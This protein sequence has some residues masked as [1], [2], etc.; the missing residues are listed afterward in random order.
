MLMGGDGAGRHPMPRPAIGD[1]GLTRPD[2]TTPLERDPALLWLDKN[3]NGDPAMADLV[4]GL[5]AG[6][7]PGIL[8]TYP[9]LT[10][11]YHLLADHVGVDPSMIVVTGG[12][13]GGIRSVFDAFV[14]PGDAVLRF[15][16][17]Y[18]MY[19]VYGRIYGAR[20]IVVDYRASTEGPV[21]D[22]DALHSTLASEAPRL[23]CLPNP[24]SPT[25]TVLDLGELVSIAEAVARHGGVLLVDEA[26]HPFDPITAVPLLVDHPNLVVVRTFSKAWALSGLRIGYCVADPDLTRLLHKVRPGYETNFVAVRM[27]EAVLA[28]EEAMLRSVARLNDGRDRFVGEMADLGFR[29]LPSGGNF[30]LVEFG[31]Y[32]PKV[33]RVLEDL[34]LYRRDFGHPSLAGFSRF[35]ATTAD[36]FVPVVARIRTVIGDGQVTS[37]RA[38]D[39]L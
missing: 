17:T 22:L 10:G 27:A 24:A 33:H 31:D 35:S 12:A 16:P 32:A 3:E 30:L 15:E 11:L 1:A 9:E 39:D 4:A 2:W 26:Y 14:S 5:L 29:T 38:S 23:V 21:L 7:D 20:Q 18:A 36:R 13:D 8:S 28:E 34:V 37:A 6:L 25:G 19:D